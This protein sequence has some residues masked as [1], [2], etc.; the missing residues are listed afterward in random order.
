MKEPKF[1]DSSGWHV[2]LALPYMVKAERGKWVDG[3][4]GSKRSP[5]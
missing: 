3:W 1:L 4:P 5:A 2:S